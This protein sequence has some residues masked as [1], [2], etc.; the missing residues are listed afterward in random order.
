MKFRRLLGEEGLEELFALTIK[1]AVGL[2][3]IPTQALASVVVDTTVQ[4][5]AVAPT[6]AK[7]LE[8]ARDKLVQ[9][10][11]EAGIARNQTLPR[12]AASCASKPSAVQS[13]YV[14]SSWRQ[15]G[16]RADRKAHIILGFAQ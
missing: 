8:T 16:S 4:E 14:F 10:A 15:R 1:L 3:L 2:Q 12:K 7:L 9:A 6:D 5:K 11:K 13:G